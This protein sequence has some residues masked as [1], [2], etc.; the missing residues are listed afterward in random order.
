MRAAA[1]RNI[2]PSFGNEMDFMFVKPED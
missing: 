1:G 2:V